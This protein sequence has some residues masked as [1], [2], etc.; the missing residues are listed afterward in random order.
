MFIVLPT[1]FFTA[2]NCLY[3]VGRPIFRQFSELLMLSSVFLVHQSVC[4]SFFLCICLFC[5]L[6]PF[7]CHFV[8]LFSLICFSLFVLLPVLLGFLN[9]QSH[10]LW[11]LALAFLRPYKC[12]WAYY[13]LSFADGRGLRGVRTPF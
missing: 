10:S 2:V 7:V 8:C 13:I 3:R 11:F 9:C 4:I 12:T 5:L 1:V 6:F